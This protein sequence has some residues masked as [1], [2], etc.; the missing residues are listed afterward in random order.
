MLGLGYYLANVKYS[1]PWPTYPNYNPSGYYGQG[2][3]GASTVG[4][5]L[6]LG[7]ELGFDPNSTL[8]FG[9][10]FRFV[11][12][13][14]LLSNDLTGSAAPPGTG[15]YTLE[16]YQNKLFFVP[17]SYLNSAGRDYRYAVL[18]FSGVDLMIGYNYYFGGPETPVS[19]K[20]VPA[21]NQPVVNP[22]QETS[23]GPM[24]S[25][26]FFGTQPTPDPQHSAPAV[27]QGYGGPGIGGFGR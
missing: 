24:H 12:F 5:T 25:G 23:G 3:F 26:P 15:P 7:M 17:Q 14:R 19:Y 4:G 16:I 20:R 1:N 11:T 6:G 22:P 18:D 21:A 9:G 2:N 8:D 10:R 13:N 27:Y